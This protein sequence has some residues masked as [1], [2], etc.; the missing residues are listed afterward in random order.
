M[1]FRDVPT[2]MAGCFAREAS[3]ATLEWLLSSVLALV[4]FQINSLSA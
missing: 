2:E 4:C 3:L 1:F